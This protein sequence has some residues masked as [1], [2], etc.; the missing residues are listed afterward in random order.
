MRLTSWW[1]LRNQSLLY[2]P[3]TVPYTELPPL[4]KGRTEIYLAVEKLTSPLF[5][6]FPLIPLLFFFL[7]LS[8]SRRWGAPS[9]VL[10]RVQIKWLNWFPLNLL[11][12]VLSPLQAVAVD[13]AGIHR[14]GVLE[15]VFFFSPPLR[16]HPRNRFCYS[17][18]THCL[19]LSWDHT[20]NQ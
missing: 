7:C 17:T 15:V 6:P 3:Y 20:G 9:C 10:I 11:A 8:T 14:R 1:K 16:I 19:I 2:C 18:P 4:R 12:Y 5:L 13:Q